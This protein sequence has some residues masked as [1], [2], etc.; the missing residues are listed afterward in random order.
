V[1][2]VFEIGLCE[3]AARGVAGAEKENV[4]HAIGHEQ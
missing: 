1:S 2:A 3:D 4:V